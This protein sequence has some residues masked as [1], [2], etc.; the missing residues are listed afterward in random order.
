MKA[1]NM[2]TEKPIVYTSA[3]SVLQIAAHEEVICCRSFMPW[4]KLCGSRY[5]GE[6]S[7][8]RVIMRPFI[9]APGQFKRTANRRDYSLQPPCP[10]VLDH[11]K[12]S[13]RMVIG[14]G[15]IADIFAI[16]V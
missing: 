16:G 6:H 13:G 12:D 15:K 3:D 1:K 9:G 14:I 4:G 8:G 10:T 5:A 7:V 11:L 2:A